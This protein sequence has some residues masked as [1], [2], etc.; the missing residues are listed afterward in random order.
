M[1]PLTN[2]SSHEIDK[3]YD[4]K[5]NITSTRNRRAY[6]A[7][8]TLWLPRKTA[9]FILKISTNSGIDIDEI[10][11][12]EGARNFC[13]K[14]E[15]QDLSK[16][17]FFTIF[18]KLIVALERDAHLDAGHHAPAFDD[19]LFYSCIMNGKNLEDVILKA[20]KFS[21]CMSNSPRT[22]QLTTTDR[23]AI[24][25]FTPPPQKS[26]IRTAAIDMLFLSH[27]YKLF[28]WLIAESICPSRVALCHDKIIDREI[29]EENIDRPMHFNSDENIIVFNRKF[30]QKP[31]L[32][33]YQ[34]LNS[35]LITRFFELTPTPPTTSIATYIENFLRKMLATK[36]PIPNSDQIASALG[37]SGQT[38]RRHLAMENTS[39]QYLLDKCRI[40]RSIE[41][42]QETNLTLD[43][44]SELLGFSA[45]S[46]FSRAFKN[47]TGYS[48]SVFRLQSRGNLLKLQ[49]GDGAPAFESR[50]A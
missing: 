18:R 2:K 19:D 23:D 34:E 32:R 17:Q 37:K 1:Q 41:L 7:N 27:Y 26:D 30:L 29:L 22:L 46:G 36:S 16:T 45:G 9:S 44:I 50:S 33:T 40:E 49:S 39:F 11:R 25:S 24:F 13:G 20:C 48:P 6:P 35:S 12:S 10:F 43:E 28:S 42:L 4:K 31:V 14:I 47:W 5:L 38:L 3:K 8:Q 21:K 15:N